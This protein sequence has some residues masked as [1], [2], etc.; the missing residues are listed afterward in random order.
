[1]A[2]VGLS[3]EHYNRFPSEFSGGQRQRIGIARAL[4]LRPDLIVCDEPVSALDVSIQA[5]I[6]NLLEDLQDEFMLTYIFI[7]HDLSVV[8]HVSDRIAVMYLGKI[9]ETGPVEEI[10][11]QSRHPYTASLLS[12]VPVA[13]QAFQAERKARVILTGDV[14]SPVNPPSGCR[15][16]PRCPKAQ[17]ICATRGAG[18]RAQ[19]GR[20]ARAPHRVPLPGAGGRDAGEGVEG[21]GGGDGTGRDGRGAAMTLGQRGG[22]A[23]GGLIGIEI[24]REVAA[25]QD[26]ELKEEREQEFIGRTPWRLAWARLRKDRVAMVSLGFIVLLVLVAIF[27]P[28]LTALI[29]HGPNAQYTT[30]GLSLSGIPVGPGHNGFLLG[31]DDQGRDV[32]SRI[33]YGSRIS[34]EVG[35]GATGLAL[36]VGTLIGPRGRL[37]RRLDRLGARPGSWTSCCP[38]RSCSSPS[39]SSLGSGRASSC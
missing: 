19:A 27:A 2:R 1:M 6:I 3:P 30:K 37:L 8:R 32:L 25:E 36:V 35:V 14:P 17:A 29:G 38:S 21:R 24:D 18:A 7:A 9:V 20:R 28:L 13:D 11:S 22:G 39:R 10:Y 4:A 33:I 5:Q 23:S 26:P 15:F 31:T 16:H 34:L 12:A